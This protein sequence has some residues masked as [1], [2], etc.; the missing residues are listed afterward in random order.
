[1]AIAARIGCGIVAPVQTRVVD[2]LEPAVDRVHIVHS[3]QAVLAVLHPA[4]RAMQVVMVARIAIPQDLVT[5]G[6]HLHKPVVLV[7]E[8]LVEEL[9]LPLLVVREREHV[10]AEQIVAVAHVVRAQTGDL[11]PHPLDIAVW[12][13]AVL[14]MH[15]VVGVDM[16]DPVLRV[17]LQRA[18]AV[19]AVARQAAARVE[20]RVRGVDPLAAARRRERRV[21][22]VIGKV[23]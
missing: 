23:T 5:R 18:V 6:L 13:V 10:A 9:I 12:V 17:A 2:R 4:Q 16:R 21:G 8:V 22:R 7:I 19:A 14:R 20:R 15:A 1:M 11:L 3:L